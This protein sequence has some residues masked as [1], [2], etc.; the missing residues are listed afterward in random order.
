MHGF[1][2]VTVEPNEPVFHARWEGRVLGMVFQV[3]GFG[4]AT[5]DAFRH[6]IERMNPAA[7]L[8]A[9]YYGRWLAGLETVLVDAGVLAP[10]EVDAR[11]E[12]KPAPC[13]TF[14]PADLPRRVAGVVRAV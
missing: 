8:T 3:V 1:G 11:I 6:G 12:G 10:G 13:P 4:W 2:P 9:D 5:I 7:Y 14:P